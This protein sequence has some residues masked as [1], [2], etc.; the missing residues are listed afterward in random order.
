VESYL[1]TA[2][3]FY[4]YYNIFLRKKFRRKIELFNLFLILLHRQK[5]ESPPS[6]SEDLKLKNDA[7]LPESIPPKSMLLKR[8]Y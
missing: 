5:C 1:R 8:D 6:S 2:V 7:D 4:Y 3:N